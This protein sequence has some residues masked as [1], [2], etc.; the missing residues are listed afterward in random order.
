MSRKPFPP[1]TTIGSKL[2]G[3]MLK[4]V[5][6]EL[7]GHKQKHG[8][9]TEQGWHLDHPTKLL[10]FG[11]R[12]GCYQWYFGSENEGIKRELQGSKDAT[13]LKGHQGDID[14]VAW[15]PLDSERLATASVDKTVRLW[16]MRSPGKAK[17]VITTAGENINVCWS[18]DGRYIS[19]GNKDDVISFI[20]LRGGTDSKSGKKEY[21]SLLSNQ[22]TP[23]K[24]TPQIVIVSNSTRLDDTRGYG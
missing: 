6:K 9:W 2:Q 21:N 20:D 18:P 23:S 16:D 8:I 24:R 5:S 10:E 12:T 1:T 7:R 14:Q 4:G 22:S 19:V 15:D 11:M 17:S 3:T 13:D